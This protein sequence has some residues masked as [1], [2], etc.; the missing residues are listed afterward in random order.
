[1]YIYTAL[2][3]KRGYRGGYNG[4]DSFFE[5]G[6][7]EK[8]VPE[9]PER[10]AGLAALRGNLLPRAVFEKK[11]GWAIWITKWSL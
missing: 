5:G 2:K 4:G 11:R 1:M 6:G 7:G 9:H 10:G 8:V 3:R